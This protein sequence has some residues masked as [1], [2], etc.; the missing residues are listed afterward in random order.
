VW[1]GGLSH[2]AARIAAEAGVR[3][4]LWGVGVEAFGTGGGG[5]GGFRQMT[6][7][8]QVLV[9]RD[10]REL[11][12]LDAEFGGRPGLVRGTVADVAAQLRGLP[13]AWAVLAP[14]DYLRRPER[15]VET[16]SLVAEAVR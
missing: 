7:G 14:L 10:A 11:A 6:W 4:N 1:I 2:G 15:A 9:G 13:V 12:E 3:R 8:G 16:V 5:G